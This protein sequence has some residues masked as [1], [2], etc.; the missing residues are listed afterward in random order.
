M[1]TKIFAHGGFMNAKEAVAIRIK[2]LCD[3]HNTNINELAHNINVTPST[4]YTM[5]NSKSMNPGV[6]SIQKICDGLGISL[7]EFFNSP[8]FD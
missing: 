6:V 1:K 5:I 2:E 4:I 7:K 8:L 3:S